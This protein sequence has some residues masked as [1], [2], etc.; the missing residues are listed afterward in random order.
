MQGMWEREKEA[1]LSHTHSAKEIKVLVSITF[2]RVLI[3]AAIVHQG[4]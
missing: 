2:N 1:S 3:S 4:R